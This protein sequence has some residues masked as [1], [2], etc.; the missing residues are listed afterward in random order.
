MPSKPPSGNRG[1]R[2]NAVTGSQHVGKI[3]I[4]P[5][6]GSIADWTFFSLRGVGVEGD[7]D[8]QLAKDQ[9]RNRNELSMVQ[10]LLQ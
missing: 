8:V 10:S 6:E 5:W 1:I 9:Q 7:V 4:R 3:G 2:S